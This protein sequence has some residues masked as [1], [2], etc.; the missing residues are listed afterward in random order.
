M[1]NRHISSGLMAMMIALSGCDGAAD[2]SGGTGGGATTSSQGGAP[3]GGAGGTGGEGATGG[4]GATGGTGGA[5]DDLAALSDDFEDA[6][7]LSD[8]KL[9]HEELGQPAP[10]TALDI[11]ATAPGKLTVVPTVSAWYQAGMAT[12]LYKEVTGDFLVEV[13][14][15]AFQKG[16][17]S[18]APTE[19]YNSAGLLIRDPAST[20][21]SQ[22]WL[23]YNIGYQAEFI[24]VEGK[25]TRNSQSELIL[26]PTGGAHAAVLRMCRVGDTVR[27]LRRL[28]GDTTWTETHTFPETFLQTPAFTLPQTVQVGLID[29]AYL[30]AGLRAEFEYIK[31]SRPSSPADCTAD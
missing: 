16:T 18:D 19:Q 13:D 27:M 22:T 14:A 11:G 29:N 4:A 8:W 31:F 17:A 3:D 24:G 9:L 25:A 6:S 12:F 1:R 20:L 28:A 15:A 2:G 23:M 21:A 7:T 30:V 26:I 10:Y 5:A